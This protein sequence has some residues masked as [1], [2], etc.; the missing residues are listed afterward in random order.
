MAKFTKGPWRA[1]EIRIRKANA[2]SVRNTHYDP[3]AVVYTTRADAE[4]MA[5][6]P[7]LLGSLKHMVAIVRL[8]EGELRASEKAKYE[9]ARALI[10]ELNGEH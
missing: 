10:N 4:L 3:I 6:A 1:G 9:A 7:K 5:V 2:W 8:R